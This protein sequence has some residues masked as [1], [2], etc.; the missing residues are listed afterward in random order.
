MLMNAWYGGDGGDGKDGKRSTLPRRALFYTLLL[1][2]LMSV[3]RIMGGRCDG[4][5]TFS[6]RKMKDTISCYF[7]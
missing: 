3:V 7:N 4:R 5:L 2:L 1:C 6:A